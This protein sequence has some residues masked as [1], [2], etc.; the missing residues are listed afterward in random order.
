ML[1]MCVCVRMYVFLCVCVC[2]HGKKET[3]VVVARGRSAQVCCPSLDP[4]SAKAALQLKLRQAF[5]IL[6]NRACIQQCH[7]PPSQE[8]PVLHSPCSQQP[9]LM[10]WHMRVLEQDAVTTELE[11]TA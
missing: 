1:C 4:L 5:S 10:A 8:P 2:V 11:N 9:S 6:A 3:T 7:N